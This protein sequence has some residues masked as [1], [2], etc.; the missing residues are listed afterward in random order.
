M[1]ERLKA[2]GRILF[3]GVIWVFVLSIRVDGRTVFYHAHD[4]LVNNQVVAA[5]EAQ[6]TRAFHAAVD[7]ASSGAGHLADRLSKGFGSSGS[8]NRG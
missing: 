6:A 7:M 3:Q 5:V 8:Q 2:A 1:R 4:V